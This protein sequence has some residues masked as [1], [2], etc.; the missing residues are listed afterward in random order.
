M[1]S[2]NF[3]SGR[4]LCNSL[5]YDAVSSGGPE[6]GVLHYNRRTISIDTDFEYFGAHSSD[7]QFK[8]NLYGYGLVCVCVCAVCGGN[9]KCIFGICACSAGTCLAFSNI[10]VSNDCFDSN[11]F[12]TVY[13]GMYYTNDTHTHT[14][15]YDRFKEHFHT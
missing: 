6:L 2:S 13:T 3:S 8:L 12:R 5:L 10:N 11:S 15:L 4:F 7:L 9:I 1:F 14:P